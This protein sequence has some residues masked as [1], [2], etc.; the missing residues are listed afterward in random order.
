MKGSKKSCVMIM[1]WTINCVIY[2]IEFFFLEAKPSADRES[3]VATITCKRSGARVWSN[4]RSRCLPTD[5]VLE[6]SEM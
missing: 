5:Y 1:V 3:L 2:Q 6:N 4:P